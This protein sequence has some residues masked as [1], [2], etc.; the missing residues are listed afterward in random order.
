[1]ADY[2]IHYNKNHSKSNGQFV[3]GDGDGDGQVNDHA[4]RSEGKQ[5]KRIF[6]DTARGRAL[7]R[8]LIATAAVHVGAMVIGTAIEKGAD[9]VA[10]RMARKIVDDEYNKQKA[11]EWAHQQSVW[12]QAAS[13]AKFAGGD[14]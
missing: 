8:G 1:M 7:K 6:S 12:R 9:Y 11:A 4:Q 13:K 5:K 2:L 14:W 3:S 10:G